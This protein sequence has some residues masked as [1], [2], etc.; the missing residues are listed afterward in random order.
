M[1]LP[2]LEER[3]DV[4]AVDEANYCAYRREIESVPGLTVLEAPRTDASTT[5]TLSLSWTRP[6]RG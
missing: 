3:D 2:L 6:R 1:G 4:I 5:S